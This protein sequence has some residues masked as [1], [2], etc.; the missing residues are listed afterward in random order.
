MRAQSQDHSLPPA[1]GQDPAEE[2]LDFP[3][4]DTLLERETGTGD[5]DDQLHPSPAAQP[6]QGTAGSSV[7]MAGQEVE[8][9]ILDLGSLVHDLGL[10]PEPEESGARDRGKPPRPSGPTGQHLPPDEA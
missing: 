4:L 8:D 7:S 10:E 2:E 6:G 5:Q 1:S 9:E 3:D